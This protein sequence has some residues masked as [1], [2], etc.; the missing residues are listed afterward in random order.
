MSFLGDQIRS[1]DISTDMIA[2]RSTD[3][4][5]GVL[6][7]YLRRRGLQGGLGDD[8]ELGRVIFRMV[9]DRVD[10]MRRSDAPPR[11]S[12]PSDPKRD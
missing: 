7:P 9:R 6:E 10:Q 12:G 4:I 1:L 8:Q 3:L 5:L 11:T 2:Q